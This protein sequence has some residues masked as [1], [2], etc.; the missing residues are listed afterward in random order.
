MSCLAFLVSAVDFPL[1]REAFPPVFGTVPGTLGTSAERS[2]IS[3]HQAAG[4][5]GG[6]YLVLPGRR[7]KSWLRRVASAASPACLG[8]GLSA[9]DGRPEVAARG[10]CSVLIVA[11]VFLE[12]HLGFYFSAVSSCIK[13]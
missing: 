2:A 12:A 1:G 10:G 11:I 8:T 5:K 13:K 3:P 6:T 9:E 4:R 7:S